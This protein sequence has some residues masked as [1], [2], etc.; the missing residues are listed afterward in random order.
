[1]S[2]RP[3]L[4]GKGGID[5]DF[6]AFHPDRVE[7]EEAPP[8]YR[9]RIVLYVLLVL[10]V[11]AVTWASLARVDRVITARGETVTYGKPLVLQ[12]LEPS[13]VQAVH[14]RE[15]MVV[16]KGALLVTL[17]PTF[18][19]ADL[20]S[21][22]R[23]VQSLRTQMDRLRCQRGGRPYRGVEGGD[24]AD[25]ALQRDIFVSMKTEYDSQLAMYTKEI[26]NLHAVITTKQA[27]FDDIMRQ[28]DLATELEDMHKDVYDKGAVSKSEYLSVLN[29]RLDLERIAKRLRNEIQET[30]EKIA[31][32]E[33]EREAYVGNWGRT[34]ETQMVDVRREIDR[35]EKQVDKAERMS[36]LVELRAPVRGVVLTVADRSA[37]SVLDIA[38]PVV[39]MV[40]LDDPIE[41]EVKIKAKDIGYVRCDD[42]ARIKLDAYEFQKHGTVSGTVSWISE[43]SFEEKTLAGSQ[44]TYTSRLGITEVNLRNVP[45]DFRLLPGM[46]VSAEIKVGTRRLITYFLYPILRY[47]DESMREP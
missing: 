27:E 36:E 42:E 22:E 45:E 39:T 7:I 2:A 35:L 41:V 33:A 21:V 14:V 44:V 40:S 30:R 32:T 20:E 9:G 46:T 1:M 24:P 25:V 28:K 3:G 15:G 31:A 13:V 6:L 10:L 5:K 11:A 19:S 29:Q 17:D 38:E 26:A 37:G 34:L 47:L 8:P 43:D 12:A 16:E 23:Q 4:P 18:A